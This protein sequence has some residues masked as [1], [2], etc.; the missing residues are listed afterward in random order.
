VEALVGDVCRA[1]I[2]DFVHSGHRYEVFIHPQPGAYHFDIMTAW[3]GPEGHRGV[4]FISFLPDV[5]T[6]LLAA[7]EVTNH[8]LMLLKD[9]LVGLIEVSSQGT[10]DRTGAQMTLSPDQQ[11]N[12]TAAVPIEH[13]RWLL[14]DVVDGDLF[15]QAKDAIA[16]ETG[17]VIV[18]LT[19]VTFVMFRYLR[20]SENQ[21]YMAEMELRRT[22]HE[23]SLQVRDRTTQLS[24]A[25]TELRGEIEE[26][27]QIQ[28]DLKIRDAI[29]RSILSQGLRGIMVIDESGN[30]ITAN[31]KAASLFGYR[32]ESDLE[33]LRAGELVHSDDDEPL[34]KPRVDMLQANDT[35]LE[36]TE[37]AATALHKDG[38]HFPIQV[39][40]SESRAGRQRVYT[41]FLRLPNK[42]AGEAAHN[43][44]DVG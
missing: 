26:R 36:E 10:R 33:G 38:S 17:L 29:L 14:V 30:V 23:L 27:T 44:S 19:L 21:R 42:P 20:R 5:I 13:T 31:R 15:G 39:T 25:R 3:K 41:A 32:K 11:E 12:V 8:S 9:D 37:H 24:E 4:F 34:F 28:K 22:H 35:V 2:L 1:D 43:R 40:V 16:R 7:T 6:R 18:L